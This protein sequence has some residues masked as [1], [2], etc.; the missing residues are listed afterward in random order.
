[1]ENKSSALR[2]FERQIKEIGHPEYPFLHQTYSP[3]SRVPCTDLVPFIS[4]CFEIGDLASVRCVMCGLRKAVLG[5]SLVWID[6]GVKSGSVGVGHRDFPRHQVE[7]VAKLDF[8]RYVHFADKNTY[9]QLKALFMVAEKGG[10]KREFWIKDEIPQLLAWCLC[11]FRPVWRKTIFELLD[12]GNAF[13]DERTEKGGFWSDYPHFKKED[14]QVPPLSTNEVMDKVR[15]LSSAA[16]MQ[17]FYA[18]SRLRPGEIWHE[19]GGNTISDL[20]NYAIRSFGIDIPKT[21]TEIRDTGLLARSREPR[22]L[23]YRMTRK[24]LIKAC[25]ET[26]AHFRKS[27]RKAKILEALESD[28]PDYVKTKL[29]QLEL[30]MLNPEYEDRLL[31]LANYAEKLVAPFKVLCFI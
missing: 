3:S 15:D 10:W 23:M 28:A 11:A 31:T 9:Y 8:G 25:E 4:D 16:R 29:D 18:V 6:D 12:R 5:V 20:T 13:I 22:A 24:D 27:W 19:R 14:L 17:L 7:N 21:S 26:G 1:M 2:Q 30:V